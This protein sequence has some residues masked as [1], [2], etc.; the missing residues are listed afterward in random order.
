MFAEESYEVGTCGEFWLESL[1]HLVEQAP[2]GEQDSLRLTYNDLRA[3][4]DDRVL[5]ERCIGTL[6]DFADRHQKR[7]LLIVENLNMLF[8]DIGDPEVGWQLRKTLQTEPRIILLGSAT[9]RFDEIDSSE[10]ALYDLFRLITLR[11]LDTNECEVLWR[12]V[13]GEPSTTRAVRP[14]AILTGSNPRLLTIIAR[15]GSGQS[16]REL[17]D[18]LLDL[19]DEHTEYFKSHLE[20]LPPQERRVYLALARLWKPSTAREIADLA[21]LDTNKCSA[22]LGRLA[23]RGAVVVEGGTPRRRE[24]YLTE[25]LYNIYYL[26]RRGQGADRLVRALIDFMVFLYSPTELEAVIEEIREQALDWDFLSKNLPQQTAAELIREALSLA[27]T[28]QTEEA[29]KLFDQIIEPSETYH[30]PGIDFRVAVAL[31]G[32][33]ALF[34]QDGQCEDAIAV[35]NELIRKFGT[36]KELEFKVLTIFALFGRGVALLMRGNAL[37]AIEAF[38]QAF[39]DPDLAWTAAL[40]SI[41][42]EM[43]VTQGMAFIQS[44]QSEKAVEAFDH[45]L[46]RC[47]MAK[48]PELTKTVVHALIAKAA[49]L[50]QMGRTISESEF[51]FLLTCFAKEEKLW[52]NCVQVSILFAAAVPPARALEIISESPAAP[53]F[54]PLVTALELELG[55]ETQVAKEVEEVALDIRHKLVELRGKL[56]SDNPTLNIGATVSNQVSDWMFFTYS[57]KPGQGGMLETGQ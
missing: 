20:S 53:L 54:L 2:V 3:V 29:L 1:S 31:A 50:A 19:V 42:A 27:G 15:F 35:G 48:E 37:E 9:S 14:L 7:L 49:A 13:S 12:T 4:R 34:V 23:Q 38:D 10:R 39:A 36:R 5:A 21:R 25:R 45:V 43:M 56:Q 40:N 8:S 18:N 41:A 22:L 44:N 33:S 16:F 17:M 32:K 55:Q 6:L 24:Y 46:T 26:L 51:S 28:G 30:A 47:G 57:P 52:A 11:P